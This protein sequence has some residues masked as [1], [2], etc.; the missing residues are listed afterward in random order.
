MPPSWA[1]LFCSASRWR[2]TSS[3]LDRPPRPSWVPSP[4]P[5][6]FC[7][8]PWALVIWCCAGQRETFIE[9][10]PWVCVAV[11][12]WSFPWRLGQETKTGT[13]QTRMRGLALLLLFCIHTF[14]APLRCFCIFFVF[15]SI[16]LFFAPLAATPNILGENCPFDFVANICKLFH[17]RKVIRLHVFVFVFLEIYCLLFFPFVVVVV[18]IL[19]TRKT[20]RLCCYCE[21]SRHAIS[22]RLLQALEHAR[23]P[24]ESLEELLSVLPLGGNLIHRHQTDSVL[25]KARVACHNENALANQ[26]MASLDCPSGCRSAAK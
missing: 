4:R 13:Y 17:L 2:P 9:P 12:G 18:L 15:Q 20:Q 19:I 1:Y 6:L 5:G 8:L 22:S 24:V 7:R 11:T 23:N 16:K 21:P 25:P 3:S 26:Y 14:I 10:T